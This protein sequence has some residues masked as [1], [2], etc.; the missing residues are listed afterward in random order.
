MSS[1]MN[2]NQQP[3][4]GGGLGAGKDLPQF[5]SEIANDKQ[6]IL[7]EPMFDREHVKQKI[8]ALAWHGRCLGFL[9]VGQIQEAI[10]LF[11]RALIP[12]DNPN[13][14]NMY[15]KMNDHGSV[16]VV[17][18]T[19]IIKSESLLEKMTLS[20]T[21]P[22]GSARA[23][24]STPFSPRKEMEFMDNSA[25]Q[26]RLFQLLSIVEPILMNDD[27][28]NKAISNQFVETLVDMLI[29]QS[30][31][32]INIQR[33]LNT[34]STDEINTPQYL[35][36]LIRCLTS[37][38]RAQIAVDQVAAFQNSKALMAI[39]QIMKFAREEEMIANS[40]KII[41]YCVKE[42]R[43]LQKTVLEFPD[44]INLMIGGVFINFDNSSFINGEMK[45]IL[46]FFT[47][48]KDYVYLI[49]P[50]S[51]AI[52]A[53][54]PSGLVKQFPILEQISNSYLVNR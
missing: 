11:K 23:S 7:R 4:G 29:F 41:R 27:N 10:T 16:G 34:E 38:I 39:V 24:A 42:E 2:G 3:Q 32:L 13:I 30:Q 51:I 35:K 50:D 6:D 21:N 36:V 20:S 22:Q 54:H 25:V 46:T 1:L 15:I 44:M 18:L 40:L 31:N 49:K 45:Q 33:N 47:R 53:K 26:R 43:Y 9:G 19:T 17:Q 52:L 14:R 37:I 12:A 5:A 28:V 48:K 8:D